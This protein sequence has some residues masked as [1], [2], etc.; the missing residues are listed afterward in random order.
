MLALA[1]SLAPAAAQSPDPD[2]PP[3]DPPGRWRQ[4]TLDDATSDSKCVGQF[5]TP[6]CAV[7]TVIACFTRQIDDLCTRA[8]LDR[9]AFEFFAGRMPRPDSFDRYRVSRVERLTE[10]TIQEI[11]RYTEGVRA[12]DIRID[13]HIRYCPT[14]G[15]TNLCRPPNRFRTVIYTTRRTDSGWRIVDRGGP[16][17]R[18]SPPK[19]P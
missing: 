13:L 10:R 16:D 6:L 8:S 12:G 2:L 18:W 3:V 15:K 14:D 9:P 19:Q 4:M 1:A 17:I 7:E 11:P 5:D